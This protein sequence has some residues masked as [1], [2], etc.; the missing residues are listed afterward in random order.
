MITVDIMDGTLP[1]YLRR[2]R[3]SEMIIHKE[4]AVKTNLDTAGICTRCGGFM[5]TDRYIDL[6]GGI[7][8][9]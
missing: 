9:L 7:D 2:T 4:I 5:V 3:E 6:M 8:Q 1:D